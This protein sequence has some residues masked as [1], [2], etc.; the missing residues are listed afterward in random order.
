[1]D[2]QKVLFLSLRGVPHWRDDE[3]IL[4]FRALIKTRLLRHAHGVTRN[5]PFATFYE[6]IK[7]SCLGF[8]YA[9]FGFFK[10][11]FYNQVINTPTLTL[12]HPGGGNFGSPSISPPLAGGG[13]GE[14]DKKANSYT[15]QLRRGRE[16]NMIHG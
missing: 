2:S 3:A 7:K 11:T 13:W 16:E 1:M 9:D 4:S 6:I 8:R 5:D 14:G 15:I 10:Y 12:P